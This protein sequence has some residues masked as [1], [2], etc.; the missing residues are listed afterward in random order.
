MQ[1]FQGTFE[2]HKRSFI[3]DFSIWMTVPLTWEA[4][5]S[6]LLLMDLIL[7]LAKISVFK[8]FFRITFKVD[9][10]FLADSVS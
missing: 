8:L 2:S 5:I 1:N 4:S 7:A 9:N 6:N 10:T 3:S